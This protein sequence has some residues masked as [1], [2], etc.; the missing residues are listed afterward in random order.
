MSMYNKTSK[1]FENALV[2][3]SKT[4]TRNKTVA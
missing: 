2:E 3:E 4:S 1:I